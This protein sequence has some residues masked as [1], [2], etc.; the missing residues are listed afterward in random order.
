MSPID[1]L[2]L[3]NTLERFLERNEGFKI[4]TH[5]SKTRISILGILVSY[6]ALFVLFARFISKKLE[7]L[8]NTPQAFINGNPELMRWVYLL[9][10]GF[11]LLVALIMLAYF[12]WAMIDVWGL[13]VCVN[14]IEIRVQNTIVGFHF[15]NW[16]G[17]GSLLMEE[18][19]A[20]EGT[21]SATF[22]IGSK[23]RLRFSP[24]EHVDKLIME[25]MEH[26]KNIEIKN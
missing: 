14:S 19:D 24:V 10:A 8:D 5:S 21:R 23:T 25:I 7:V 15:R 1:E 13:Q 16:T 12:L 11:G 18:I 22:I 9:L 17:V 2:A 20:L 3:E 26:A 4:Y 6:L